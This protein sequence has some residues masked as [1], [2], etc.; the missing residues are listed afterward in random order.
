MLSLSPF[1]STVLAAPV[2]LASVLS[3]AQLWQLK[4][5][6][7][8]RMKAAI[9]EPPVRIRIYSYLAALISV[10]LLSPLIGL[11]ILVAY[12]AWRL[13]GRGL[14]RPDFTAKAW[15]LILITTALTALAWVSLTT[16]GLSATTTWSLTL[17]L[18]PPLSAGAVVLTKAV[19]SLPKRHLITR[20]MTLRASLPNLNVIG[21]TGS[22]GKT[23]TKHFLSQLIPQATATKQ[24]RNAEYPVA[25]DMLEQLNPDTATYIVE[26][27]AYRRG[28]IAALATLT[29]PNIG[30]ITAIGNQHLA[31]FGS[32]ANILKTKWE[33]I[34][35]LPK[36]GI[37]VLNAD[38]E[39]LQRVVRRHGSS[40]QRKSTEGTNFR[41]VGV[42]GEPRVA[43]R[44]ISDAKNVSPRGSNILWYST[45]Q[46]ADVYVDNI[47]I[48]PGD[49]TCRL[50]I[51]DQTHQVAI[52]L[53]GAGAL[54][55]VVAAVAAAHA[56][57]V[58]TSTIVSRLPHLKPYPRTM[59]VITGASGAT[60]IDDSYSANQQGV[61]AA[62][63]HLRKFPATDKRI[64][65]TPL[66]ELGEE[67]RAVHQRIGQALAES[68]ATVY[69]YGTA[70]HQ[71]LTDAARGN[72]HTFRSPHQLAAQISQHITSST[73]I[74]IEG[75][76]PELVRRKLLTLK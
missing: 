76:V 68:N 39:A 21:I 3:Q 46:P 30:L 36:N 72:V 25:Q 22:Y 45:K 62:I 24:H 18:I 20:A 27:G 69:V 26:M 9:N 38:D 67:A 51:K 11:L 4:E 66:I 47:T 16:E 13:A 2:A 31:T 37:A 42:G 10:I 28:E 1:V 58:A 63:G 32:A 53:A 52:P 43:G 14:L 12:H 60:I 59:Q 74:L 65:L 61:L 40:Q 8:D 57:G 71:G 17:L 73:V 5:Y 75:R 48:N 50:H 70:Y 41:G 34:E 15:L 29:K 35:A 56:A 19:T 49:I 44:G 6:R 33:L 23:S 7:L 64:V 54:A 55:G